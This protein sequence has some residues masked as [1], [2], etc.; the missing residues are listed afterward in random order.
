MVD[1]PFDKN[2]LELGFAVVGERV[3]ERVDVGDGLDAPLKSTFSILV[4]LMVF[5]LFN[6]PNLN[7]VF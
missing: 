7:R 5:I 6:F 2:A 1:F 3:D 4:R